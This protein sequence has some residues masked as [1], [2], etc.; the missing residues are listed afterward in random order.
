MESISDYL[1]QLADKLDR[2][3]KKEAADAV[4]K[5]IRTASLEKIAQYVG[6]IGYVLKQNRAMANCIRKKRVSSKG[7]MQEVVLSCLK[8]YQ[9]GQDY[10]DTDWTSKYAKVI[11]TRPDLF[12]DAHIC[13]LAQ[14]GETNNIPEHLKNVKEAQAI[15]QDKYIQSI[16]DNFEQLG[17]IFRKEARG[18]SR[19]P[20]KVAA[21][22][23]PRSWWQRF[24][25]PTDSWFR[26]TT[27]G[28]ND[29]ARAEM[30]RILEKLMEIT[31]VG[32]QLRLQIS[33]LK[34]EMTSTRSAIDPTVQQTIMDLD[35]DNWKDVT[36]LLATIENNLVHLPFDSA[37]YVRD[38]HEKMN[39]I[40]DHLNEIQGLMKNLRQRDAVMGWENDPLPSPTDE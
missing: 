27:R 15:V 5:I 14:I 10:N 35:P 25:R 29:D 23:S 21:P 8:E 38:I 1:V 26:S 24:L 7:P 36:Q 37:T 6:V 16:I 17:E 12:S 28:R 22:P 3:D 34:H 39:N 2:E 13:L 11:E 19:L 9:D 33:R 40:Y 18:D 4:D 20:F 30:D 31:Y 32:Q